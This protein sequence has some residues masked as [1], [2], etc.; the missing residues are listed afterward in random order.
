MKKAVSLKSVKFVTEV[1]IDQY[2][3]KGV[4]VS[5]EFTNILMHETHISFVKGKRLFMVPFS[6]CSLLEKL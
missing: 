1:I 5:D 6:N 4:M 3:I 2:L